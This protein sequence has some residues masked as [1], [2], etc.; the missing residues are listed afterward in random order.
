VT[1]GLKPELAFAKHAI[2]L[3]GTPFLKKCAPCNGCT[4][5]VVDG[6]VGCSNAGPRVVFISPVLAERCNG[7]NPFF[8]DREGEGHHQVSEVFSQHHL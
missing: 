4:G 2:K 7:K 1:K 3:A 6:C 5:N 8:R